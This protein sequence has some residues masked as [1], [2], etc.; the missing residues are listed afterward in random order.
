MSQEQ[1]AHHRTS[2]DPGIDGFWDTIAEAGSVALLLDYDGTLAPFHIDRLK[3]VPATGASETIEQLRDETDTIVALVSGRPVAEILQLMPDPGVTIIGTHG[4]ELREPGND[5]VT[6]SITSEQ[7]DLLDRAYADAKRFVGGNRTERKAATVA[8][9]FRGLD[10]I[11]ARQFQTDIL[12]RWL[13]YADTDIVEIRQFNG[14]VEMRVLGRD[15]GTAVAD[16]LDRCPPAT[17]PVYIGDDDTDEDAFRTVNARQGFAIRVG[18][19]TDAT[20][21]TGSL[22]TCDDVVTFL[23]RWIGA[24]TH[25]ENH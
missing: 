12:R 17:L 5:T 10:R 16:F 11:D 3:A 21:A 4:F 23:Q 22:A 15:K 7:A 14:G 2:D 1:A 24:R 18:E 13:G 25:S 19:L 8:A 9:H 6:A 20:Q